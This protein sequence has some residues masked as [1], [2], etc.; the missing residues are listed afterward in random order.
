MADEQNGQ[1]RSRKWMLAV[2][3]FAVLTLF[4]GFALLRFVDDASGAALVIG[5]WI[6]GDTTILGG[7]GIM[8][9]AE[10]RAGGK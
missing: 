2:A 3:S 1:K 9:V 4:V 8:N 10:K 7:Y 5:A 6:G